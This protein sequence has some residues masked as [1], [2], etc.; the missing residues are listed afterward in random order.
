MF[1]LL[2]SMVA[3]GIPFHIIFGK[4]NSYFTPVEVL[5]KYRWFKMPWTLSKVKTM[6]QKLAVSPQSSK[7][8][9]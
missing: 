6:H 9:V 1:S 2:K 7:K 3:D 8:D 4:Q 5:W